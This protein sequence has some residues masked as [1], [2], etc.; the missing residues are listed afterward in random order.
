MMRMDRGEHGCTGGEATIVVADDAW[1]GQLA[2]AGAHLRR[3][4]QQPA[5]DDGAPTAEGRALP[6]PA[7]AFTD[8]REACNATQ[9]ASPP[10]RIRVA[11]T[12]RPPKPSE[13]RKRGAATT[14]TEDGGAP[15]SSG[16]RRRRTTRGALLRFDSIT[17]IVQHC[18]KRYDVEEVQYGCETGELLLR[19]DLRSGDAFESL[20]VHFEGEGVYAVMLP[21]P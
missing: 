14:L 7:N 11:E 4:A 6:T 16:K 1:R 20:I 18:R 9:T 13:G 8:V 21:E 12:T 2:L 3:A 10:G 15:T 17:Q 5:N 19:L